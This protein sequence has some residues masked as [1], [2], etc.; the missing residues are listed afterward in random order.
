MSWITS[1]HL[2]ETVFFVGDSSRE[3]DAVAARKLTDNFP[4]FPP[5]IAFVGA[6][7]TAATR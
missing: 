2:K 5:Q 4:D 6:K 3:R 7:R 1:E